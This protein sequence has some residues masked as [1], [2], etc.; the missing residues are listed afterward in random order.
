VVDAMV[1]RLE[2]GHMADL[3]VL[4]FETPEAEDLYWKVNGILGVD[5]RTGV[6]EWPPPLLSHVAG[7]SDGRLVVVEVWESQAAQQQFME[8]RLAPAFAEANVPQPTRAQ[9]FTHLGAMHRH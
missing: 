1:S 4:E 5:A 7:V 8:S 9:W 2:G 3:L 6:G